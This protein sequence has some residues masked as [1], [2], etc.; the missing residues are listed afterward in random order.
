MS[1]KPYDAVLWLLRNTTAITS[2][3]DTR[4]TH[5]TQPKTATLP[6]IAFFES[7]TFTQWKGL[8]SQDFTINCRAIDRGSALD[9]ARVV[10]KSFNGDDATGI[11]GT[12]DGFDIGRAFMSGGPNVFSEPGGHAFNAPLSITLKYTTD[13]VS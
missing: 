4:S 10:L 12:T 13:T 8:E 6:N 2:I 5:G 9:L 1:G 3:I 7:G 11:Y